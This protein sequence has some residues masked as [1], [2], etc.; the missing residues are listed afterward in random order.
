MARYHNENEMLH[1][2][3]G[4]PVALRS[5]PT[6]CVES[7]CAPVQPLSRPAAASR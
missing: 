7:I 6:A 2:E 1:D 4:R 5:E 3:R